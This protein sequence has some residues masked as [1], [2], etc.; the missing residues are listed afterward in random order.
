M[1]LTLATD[2]STKEQERA[3][4]HGQTDADAEE[5]D[6]GPLDPAI[7]SRGAAGGG[8]A[9]TFGR[10]FTERVADGWYGRLELEG[11]VAGRYEGAGAVGGVT[12]GG[13]L[14]LADGASGGGLPFSFLLGYRTPGLIGCLGV[15]ALM[16]E[17]D[18][19]D[20]DRGFGIYA[21][22]ASARLGIELGGTRLLADARALYRW[23][24][25]APD[26]AQLQVGLSMV[27]FIERPLS[28]PKRSPKRH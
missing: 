19:V 20:G 5:L 23:Q 14:W 3:L 1:E 22:F 27:H 12:L 18:E 15:G 10:V 16:F 8:L 26:R 9:G 13:E 25:G 4:A 6:P 21:P 28:A 11:L 2:G 7:Y 24:W 17:L